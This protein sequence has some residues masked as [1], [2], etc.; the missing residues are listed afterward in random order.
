MDLLDVIEEAE[1]TAA[2]K[3]RRAHAAAM[4]AGAQCRSCPLLGCR[5]GPVPGDIVQNAKLTIVGEAPGKYEVEDG[6]VFNGPSGSELEA[7]LLLGGLDREDCTI[8]NTIMCRPPPGESFEQYLQRLARLH[9]RA[10]ADAKARDEPPPPTPLTPIDCCRPRLLRE[11]AESRSRTVLA[12]GAK[13][14]AA[15]ADY[16]G[17]TYGSGKDRVGEIAVAKI[18]NQ[19]GSPIV[20]PAGHKLP[21]F[22]G[23]NTLPEDHILC[24]ALHP[25]FAMRGSR[26][27]KFVIRNDIARAAQIVTRGNY[28]DWEEPEYQ[29]FTEAR[30]PARVVEIIEANCKLFVDR[31]ALVTI[32]I[33][34][35]SKY[36]ETCEIRCI[37]MGATINGEE[38]VLV[39]PWKWMDGRNY[40]ANAEHADRV[41]LA[42]QQVLTH[43]QLVMHNGAFD[44]TV[45]L[46]HK[47]MFDATRTWCDTMIA[48]HDTDANDLPHDLGSVMRRYV[49]APMH[50]QDVDHKNAANTEKDSDLHL[51]NARDVLGTMRI[52]PKLEERV[53]QCATGEQFSVDTDLAPIARNMGTLGLVV[54]EYRRGKLS[55]KFNR[56][57]HE[58]RAQFQELVGK[59]I[60]PN[61]PPQLGAWLYD[62]LGYSPVLN[63]QGYKYEDGDAASTSAG[64]ITQLVGL[65]V[66]PQ[67]QKALEVLLQFKACEKLRSTYIDNLHTRYIDEFSSLP[68]ADPVEL[69]GKTILEERDLLSLINPTW[70]I[71]VV[72][73]G[74]WSSSPNCQNWPARA[75]GERKINPKTGKTVVKANNMR[76]MIVAPPDHAIIGADYAQIELRI[77]AIQ[78]QDRLVLKAFRDGLDPHTLNAAT[79]FVEGKNPTDAEI[80]AKYHEIA[81]LPSGKKKYY[82]TI[83]KRFVYLETYGGEEEKLFSVM[84]SERDKATGELVFPTLKPE[85]CEVWHERWHKLHPETKVWQRRCQA[86]QREY[87]WV[88]SLLDRRRRYFPGGPNKKNAVAN[89]TIQGSAA[90]IT[91]RAVLRIAEEIPFGKWSRWTGLCL[92]VHDYIGVYVPVSRVDEAAA[93]IKKCMYWEY[94]GMPFPADDPSPTWDW[95]AQG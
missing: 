78:A 17:V 19:H 63:T 74:R 25:A 62:D 28:V 89:H 23:L 92:Q 5:R 22:T 12:V 7:A 86:M 24:S 81:K 50:K 13:A 53:S 42:V 76:T 1:S 79:L 10:C 20:F 67:V 3:S 48:D 65:G 55:H 27:Y 21:H 84:A 61:S 38:F 77:Y 35:D 91:N 18:L 54:N 64:A 47:F 40:W 6:R 31:S 72:P 44:T 80:M 34:T 16:F 73:T 69:Y 32:D 33:E 41:K 60:N 56:L 11:I 66:E 30:D 8:T 43:C 71:H 58:F 82:R 45:L 85:E 39:V 88:A 93:I 29:L 59:P 68:K 94:E 2:E 95:A 9:K 57:T 90:A 4:A 36:A 15:L 70:K 52:W 75:W 51:Y 87:G 14:L 26:Q 37:G 49:E 83:A 46:R